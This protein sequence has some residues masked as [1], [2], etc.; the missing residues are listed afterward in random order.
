M[1]GETVYAATQAI[2]DLGHSADQLHGGFGELA[3]QQMQE[4]TAMLTMME[5]LDTAME[6]LDGC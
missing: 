1:S 5:N 6:I 4:H 2:A 3:E